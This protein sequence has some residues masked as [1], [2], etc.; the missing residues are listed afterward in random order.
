MSPL[1]P[2]LLLGFAAEEAKPDPLNDLAAKGEAAL[3]R[4][5]KGDGSKDPAIR[6]EALRLAEGLRRGILPGTPPATVA[7]LE[8]LAALQGSEL[9]KELKDFAE[10]P[11]AWRHLRLLAFTAPDAELRKSIRSLAPLSV[12]QLLSGERRAELLAA[13][14]TAALSDASGGAVAIWADLVR[15]DKDAG[16]SLEQRLALLRPESELAGAYLVCLVML[17]LGTP[18][19]EAALAALSRNGYA[20]ELCRRLTLLQALRL[21]PDGTSAIELLLKGNDED[22]LRAATLSLWQ[23][24]RRSARKTALAVAESGHLLAAA[25]GLILIAGDA[26]EAIQVNPGG[27]SSELLLEIGEFSPVRAGLKSDT[28]AYCRIELEMRGAQT[29]PDL[30]GTGQITIKQRL[31][32]L[33]GHFLAH[34]AALLPG[35][36]SAAIAAAN[37][38]PAAIELL[39]I[40]NDTGLDTEEAWQI[41]SVLILSNQQDDM[42]CSSARQIDLI[43]TLVGAQRQRAIIL[44]AQIALENRLPLASLLMLERLEGGVNSLDKLL[45]RAQAQLLVGNFKPA[46]I[47]LVALSEGRDNCLALAVAAGAYDLAGARAESQEALD[48]CVKLALGRPQEWRPLIRDLNLRRQSRALCLLTAPLAAATWLPDGV[49]SDLLDAL[50]RTATPGD[51]K[52]CQGI[53]PLLRRS[54]LCDPLPGP[55]QCWRRLRLAHLVLT[56]NAAPEAKWSRDLYE[57]AAPYDVAAAALSSPSGVKKDL[58]ER[59][60]D[61]LEDYPKSPWLLQRQARCL[62][63]LG[64]KEEALISARKA[65]TLVSGL[66]EE[67]TLVLCLEANGVKAEALRHLQRRLSLAP[68]SPE[69]ETV[70]SR[71]LPYNTQ[72][73]KNP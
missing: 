29:L 42:A 51:F 20:P 60:E 69:L 24:S 40:L 62:L 61:A 22:H 12:R 47:N 39:Q 21:K 16:R 19:G 11:G 73:V 67:D 66:P 8:H 6:A 50:A 36:D 44:Q 37:A 43:P 32:P 4:L 41:W 53:L 65:Q 3:E 70:A 35:G 57:R 31:N 5:D 64:R 17:R 55:E 7:R 58:L 9:D 10:Q 59:I 68:L 13:A 45:G 72:L 14:E 46:A 23:D 30:D 27:L 34:Q 49:A 63:L 25:S 15:G 33:P 52:S 2:L 48:N 26:S 28:E 38:S 56:A 54:A 18:E 71:L 1:L